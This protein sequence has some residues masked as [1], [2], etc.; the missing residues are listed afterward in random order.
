V[1]IQANK[2]FETGSCQECV[3]TIYG[4]EEIGFINVFLIHNRITLILRTLVRSYSCRFSARF[5]GFYSKRL[6]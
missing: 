2:L 6:P 5:I 1:Q 3:Q 4:D